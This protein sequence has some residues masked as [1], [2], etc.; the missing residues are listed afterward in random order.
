[1]RGKGAHQSAV[2]K[3]AQDGK[4][5][6][7]GMRQREVMEANAAVDEEFAFCGGD[8]ALA[9]SPDSWLADSACTSHIARDRD[10]F[11]DYTPTPGH[12]ISGFGKTPGLGRGIIQLEATVE[13]KNLEDNPE[14]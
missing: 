7:G 9:A 3:E 4:V 2:Q 14:E 8:M 12:Q 5:E 1:M 11:I 10:I 13:G 6:P